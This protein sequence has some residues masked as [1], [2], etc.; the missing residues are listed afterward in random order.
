MLSYKLHQ[1]AQLHTVDGQKASTCPPSRCTHIKVPMATFDSKHWVCVTVLK[2]VSACVVAC[3]DVVSLPVVDNDVC[4]DLG[5]FDVDW[6]PTL[7]G[8]VKSEVE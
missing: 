8:G 5:V 4:D 2:R 7:L 1:A 6:L 3:T